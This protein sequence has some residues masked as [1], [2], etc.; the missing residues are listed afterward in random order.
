MRR[1][2]L[3]LGLSLGGFFDGILLHQILQW[4]HLLSD[5]RAAA[6]QD[7]RV[8]LLADGLFHL[9][10]YV[11]CAHA[12]FGLWRSRHELVEA[13]AINRLAGSALLGFGGWHVLD[14]L[15]SHWI[16]G[17]HR[18]RGDVANP[19]FWDLLWVVAFGLLP[20]AAGWWLNRRPP[21]GSAP[22]PSE[23]VLLP[24]AEI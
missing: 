14:A 20:M 7:M 12:L 18:I 4:H 15:L 5:V 19:L 9:L 13:D 22:G 11:I 8:Q 23:A 2:A 6:V 17:I 16:T 21:P 3:L 1:A 24:P 10:M